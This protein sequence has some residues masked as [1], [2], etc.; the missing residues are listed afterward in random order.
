LKTE[1]Q[2]GYRSVELFR[3]GVVRPVMLVLL[4]CLFWGTLLA[5]AFVWRAL[6]AG[7]A[8]AVAT[9]VPAG[10][11][12]WGWINLA[13]TLLAMIAWLFVAATMLGAPRRSRPD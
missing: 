6:T 8:A 9:W 12:F 2:G 7:F 10:G 13:T 3:A 4:V 5:L 11:D 1:I